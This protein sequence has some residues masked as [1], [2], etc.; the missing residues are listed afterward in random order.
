MA[1]RIRALLRTAYVALG[2]TSIYLTWLLAPFVSRTHSAVYHWSGRASDLF[3]PPTIDFCAVWLL[4]TVAFL[5]ARG[6][7]WVRRVV[8]GA[9]IAFTPCMALK[10]WAYVMGT[11]FRPTIGLSLFC[12]GLAFFLIFLLLRGH[13]HGCH[14]ES[15]AGAWAVSAS[16]N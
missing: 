5:M 11:Q 13:G 7:G 10:N 1:P 4:L 9:T 16:R 14:L 8:W 2:A 6:P 12:A 3:L 15:A